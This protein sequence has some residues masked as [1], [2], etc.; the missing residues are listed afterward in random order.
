MQT[1]RAMGQA[2]GSAGPECAITYICS[3][4]FEGDDDRPTMP[5]SARDLSA[6][7][8][9]LGQA[10]PETTAVYARV[11]DGAL[12]TAASAAGG[13]RPSAR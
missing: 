8:Q 9:L 7:Q 1:L 6:V 11:P 2:G 4:R 10:K 13:W 5:L 3:C 12:L